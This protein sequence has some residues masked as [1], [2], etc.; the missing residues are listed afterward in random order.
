MIGEGKPTSAA[1]ECE[2]A[3]FGGVE[4]AGPGLPCPVGF[5]R[6]GPELPRRLLFFCSF[7]WRGGPWCGNVCGFRRDSAC[8]LAPAS[9]SCRA[10]SRR[11]VALHEW[12]GRCNLG[13]GA[14]PARTHIRPRPPARDNNPSRKLI[15]DDGRAVRGPT[16]LLLARGR[17]TKSIDRTKEQRRKKAA[18]FAIFPLQHAADDGRH[19][20]A[21]GIPRLVLRP[22][23]S[24]L[25]LS[26]VLRAQFAPPCPQ[27]PVVGN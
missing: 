12:D 18:H 9:V 7:W 25:Q 4:L 23:R 10:D 11:R 14:T 15:E 21:P 22:A 19:A 3:S 24:A 26:P 27:H 17:P 13:R 16:S 6:P 8:H 2:N 5:H 20:A 1:T